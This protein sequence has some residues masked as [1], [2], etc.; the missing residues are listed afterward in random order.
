MRNKQKAW[1]LGAI[2]MGRRAR[3]NKAAASIVG[4][5]FREHPGK[6]PATHAK[7]EALMVKH[8]ERTKCPFTGALLAPWT[9]Y[10]AQ[11]DPAGPYRPQ[12]HHGRSGPWGE[13]FV[14]AL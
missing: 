5:I 8:R 2:V 13:C 6:L 10:T 14:R 3:S 12:A 1:R 11:Q 4:S 7:R 9:G